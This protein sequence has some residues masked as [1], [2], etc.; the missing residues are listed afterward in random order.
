MRRGDLK[1]GDRIRIIELPGRGVPGYYLHPETE[2][3]YKKLIAR[4]RSVRIADIDEYGLPWY[5]FGLRRKNGRWVWHSMNV[6]DGDDNW[7]L[8]KRRRQGHATR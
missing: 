8:V 6:C 5:H 1:V 7:V 2:R 4:N 3:A